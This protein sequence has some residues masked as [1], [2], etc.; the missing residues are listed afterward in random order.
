MSAREKTVKRR[1]SFL[2][3]PVNIEI[4][5]GETRSGIGD[6]GEKW[7]KTYAVPYGE[8]DKTIAPTDGDPVDVY[9]GP[10]DIPEAKVYV[11]HQLRKDGSPDEDKVM[12]G[13]ASGPIAKLG[14][15]L[16]GPPWGFGSMDEMTL[17]QFVHG[18]L[19]A[20]RAPALRGPLH[21]TA[22]A[23]QALGQERYGS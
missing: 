10:H 21:N 9:L 13:F 2:G 11:V 15:E 8:I 17:D 22:A 7:E 5:A 19:A 20:N 18:Y 12:L 23:R 3:L 14:Y 16:H 6:E 4:E 1:V